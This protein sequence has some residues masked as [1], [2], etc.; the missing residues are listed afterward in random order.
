MGG[1]EPLI[2]R[3]CGYLPEVEEWAGKILKELN[4]YR[5]DRKMWLGKISILVAIRGSLDF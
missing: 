5:D 1:F 4:N 2:K 3:V